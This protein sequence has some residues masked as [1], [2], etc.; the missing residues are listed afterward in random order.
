MV[1]SFARRFIPRKIPAVFDDFM[2]LLS[3]P[4]ARPKSSI[5]GHDKM[6]FAIKDISRF[7]SSIC[8]I[9]LR[10]YSY[11]ARRRYMAFWIRGGG[12]AASRHRLPILKEQLLWFL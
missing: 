6:R 9:I 11:E 5:D 8:H 1:T 2:R 7:S 12:H 3:S 4:F 10:K